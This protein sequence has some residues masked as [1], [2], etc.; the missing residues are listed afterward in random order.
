MSQTAKYGGTISLW[1]L[2][3]LSVPVE[4]AHDN[5]IQVNTD[6]CYIL[7][8]TVVT[9]PTGRWEPGFHMRSSIILNIE[10]NDDNTMTIETQ[11]TIYDVIGPE[12]DPVLG[13]DIGDNI[14][15][16]FY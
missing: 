2:H 13:G 1:Q 5:G 8:G 16:I 14:I 15:K 12:G 7:S 3:T 11:N 6:N 10:Y 4:I 9:D